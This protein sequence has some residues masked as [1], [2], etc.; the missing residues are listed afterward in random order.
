MSSPTRSRFDQSQFTGS[1][2]PAGRPSASTD[3]APAVD[4]ASGA[5][6]ACRGRP[7]RSPPRTRRPG[8]RGSRPATRPATILPPRCMITTWSPSRNASSMSCVT[9]TI[10]L[11]ELALQAQQLLLQLG[12]DDRVDGAER[13]VHQQDV[14]VDRESRAR[15]RRAAAGRPRAGSGSGRRASGRGRPCRAARA[16][17]RAPRAWA[18]RGGSGTVATLSITR[19][20]GSRPEFCMT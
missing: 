13:L 9:N 6:R 8:A 1:R 5:G 12:A 4:V 18:C 11:A 2:T 17:A 16:R 3:H 7:R 14:R 20:C 10:G 19:R 15:R